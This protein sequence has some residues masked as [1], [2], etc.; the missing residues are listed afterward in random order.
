MADRRSSRRQLVRG[1]RWVAR[2]DTA[3]RK[4]SWFNK[5]SM[6]DCRNAA[7]VQ[8]GFRSMAKDEA[9]KGL[10]LKLL[11]VG[12]SGANQPRGIRIPATSNRDGGIARIL[13]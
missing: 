2:G 6:M 13:R 4:G 3:E 8:N 11:G 10:D 9:Q 5:R 12:T 7:G 1:L